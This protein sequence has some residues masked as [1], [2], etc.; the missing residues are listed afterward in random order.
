[1][2][3]ADAHRRRGV[4]KVQDLDPT[5]SRAVAE[6]LSVLDDAALRR[7]DAGRAE[8]DFADRSGGPLHSRG[9]QAG[10]LRLFRQLLLIDLK[11]VVIMDVEATTAIR[12]AEVG[13]AK[14]MLD[15]TAEQFEAVPSRLVTDAG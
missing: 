15:R 12:Q 6:Y 7:G 2:I 4:A 13:A 10:G 1:M 9:R 11:H 14:A 5:S 8:G 3:V